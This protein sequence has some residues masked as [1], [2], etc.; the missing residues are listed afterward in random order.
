MSKPNAVSTSKKKSTTSS[1]LNQRVQLP[2]GIVYLVLEVSKRERERER[3]RESKRE[4][5]RESKIEI[6]G[7]IFRQTGRP[8]AAQKTKGKCTMGDACSFHHDSSKCPFFFS[9]FQLRKAGRPVEVP[10]G[11][12]SGGRAWIASKELARSL[13]VIDDNHKQAAVLAKGVR[14]CTGTPIDSEREQRRVERVCG[15]CSPCEASGLCISG[16][17]AAENQVEFKAGHQLNETQ[18]SVCKLVPKPYGGQTYGMRIP[19]LGAISL[20]LILMSAVRTFHTLF[21]DRS[22][23]ETRKQERCCRRY[24]W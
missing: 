15:P 4:K 8:E 7:Q 12:R 23:E 22:H 24:A 6:N 1:G 3:E 10:P 16:R 21:V 11:E 17:G 9:Q 20:P 2:T 14:S 19:S 18:K 13:C 5:E